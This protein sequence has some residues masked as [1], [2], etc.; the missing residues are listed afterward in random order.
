M[1]MFTSGRLITVTSGPLNTGVT[2][3]VSA[4]TVCGGNVVGSETFRRYRIFQ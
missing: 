2:A 3:L 4:I 1:I